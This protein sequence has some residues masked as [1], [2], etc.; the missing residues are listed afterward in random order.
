MDFKVTSK[1]SFFAMLL[2]SLDYFRLFHLS[3]TGHGSYVEHISTQEFYEKTHPIVD[4]L[5]ES[6]QGIDGLLE[7]TIPQTKI[8]SNIHEF[9]TLLF[10]FIE[11]N[12]KIF[13]YS[14][15][16][17]LLDE[18]QLNLSLLNYKLKYLK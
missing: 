17:S 13:L 11:T 2:H 16:Q 10:Q 4:K 7:L 3:S 1:E 9:S 8:L 15:Q 6:T 5:I 14:F 12:R 18:I